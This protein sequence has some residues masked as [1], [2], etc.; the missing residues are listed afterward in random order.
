MKNLR[1]SADCLAL[2]RQRCNAEGWLDAAQFER[3]D[4][5]VA[6]LIEDAVRRAKSDPKPQAADLLSDVY[7]AYHS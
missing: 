5:E 6:Q 1:E 7:V 2:F 4:S 3:I